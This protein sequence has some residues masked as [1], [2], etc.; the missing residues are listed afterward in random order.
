MCIR[1]RRETDCKSIYDT[2]ENKLP[3]ALDTNQ[4]DITIS[5]KTQRNHSFEHREDSSDSVS[6]LK[7]PGMHLQLFK[8][9]NSETEDSLLGEFA[10][11]DSNTSLTCEQVSSN[12]LILKINRNKS[13]RGKKRK[14]I[15][16]TNIDKN[17]VAS[18][19]DNE[20]NTSSPRSTDNYDASNDVTHPDEN[21]NNTSHVAGLAVFDF[22]DESS[23]DTG[24][25]STYPVS[26]THLDVYKRQ[27]IKS[28]I[29]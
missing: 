11:N 10:S 15:C 28:Q 6:I 23:C 12:S 17:K 19:Y 2:I 27:G 18:I 3:T 26:Y 24:L 8:E 9:F 16:S 22:K 14:N 4:K 13:K 7:K 29:N 20:E 1:D 5:C 25:D 21:I